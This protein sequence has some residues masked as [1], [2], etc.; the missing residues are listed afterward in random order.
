MTNE[1]TNHLYSEKFFEYIERGSFSSASVIVPFVKAYLNP[2]SILDIGCGQ[3]AW[4][5]V[6]A[7]VGVNDV[8]G[9]DGDYVNTN[10]L[11]I[12]KNS[13][14]KANLNMPID[15][16]RKFDLVTSLEVAEHLSPDSSSVFVKSLTRHSDAVLFSAATPGQGGENHINERPL[17]SWREIFRS[18]GFYP[19]D[20]IRPIFK[21]CLSIEPW[22][23]FNTILYLNNTAAKKYS[24]K[25]IFK[26]INDDT[27]I[28]NYSDIKWTLRK[29]I[30]RPMP[31]KIIDWLA[32]KNSHLQTR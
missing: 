8:L 11:H 7:K 9:V 31:R 4:L 2:Q 24:N 28:P 3:G 23:R 32:I 30:I 17:E 29:L 19:Y 13:F 12:S 25:Y 27:M 16:G 18:Q 5:N 26:R 1:S 22:Y 14:Q 15:I 21:N 10:Q 20:F 6:W